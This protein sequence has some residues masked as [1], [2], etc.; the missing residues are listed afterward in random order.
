MTI[1]P[2]VQVDLDDTQW[3]NGRG[4]SLELTNK[5]YMLVIRQDDNINF[6]TAKELI[7][8]MTKILV[9]RPKLVVTMTENNDKMTNLE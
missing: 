8:N 1:I 5:C 7:E 3:I 2:T 6:S 9:A 4:P